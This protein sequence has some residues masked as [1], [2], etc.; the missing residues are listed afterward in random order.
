ME[1]RV[2]IALVL[3]FLALYFVQSFLGQPAPKRQAA[4]QTQPATQAT[5]RPAAVT[6]S[7]TAAP[8]AGKSVSA[9]PASAVALP[10][11]AE[12][13]A[14]AVEQD[15][16]VMTKVVRAVFSNRGAHLKSWELRNFLDDQ[17]QPVELVPRKMPAGATRPFMLKLDDANQ[18]TELNTALFR[19]NGEGRKEIDATRSPARIMFEF[20]DAAGLTARKTF[21]LS[22]DSYVLKFGAEVTN[23]S[24]PANVSIMWGRGLGDA[25]TSVANRYLQ[26]PQ[27]ILMLDGKVERLDP[28]S[29]SK[30]PV[31]EGN[32]RFAGVDDHYFVAAA[33]LGSTNSR[34]EFAS[35]V[36]PDPA[37]KEGRQ[38][39]SFVLNPK[40]QAADTKFFF[41]PK[42]FDLLREADP[43]FVRVI[44]FGVF[45]FLAVPLLHALNGVN[46]YLG[47]YGWSIIAL[48]VFINALIFPL[49]HKSVV[50][51]RKLQDLQ[52][53][54]KAIQARYGKLKTTDPAR[55]KMN[56]EMMSLYK[57]RGVNPASGCVP[58]LLTIP[59]LFAFY[60]LLSQAVELRGAPFGLWIK[61]LSV[62]D[63]LYVTPILMGITMFV[64]QKMT[65]STMDPAQQKMMMLMPAVFLFMFLWAPSGLVIYWFVSNLLAIAQQYFTNRLIGP[66]KLVPRPAAGRTKAVGSGK[67]PGA[68]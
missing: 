30:Q 47:N 18:T 64:Q 7:P 54:I 17:K 5:E 28:S 32:I 53:E 52:P 1:K 39:A 12:G 3:S 15:I 8:E 43:E 62:H 33:L 14:A 31:R 51:M 24:Q 11:P 44:N 50:S 29:I 63:P 37:V 48:T 67:S 23:G 57:E 59:V 66:P 4:P 25:E 2:L 58:T 45:A 56:Q 42:N 19:L 20:R 6:G 27:G 26:K 22:P 36:V 40:G 13:F 16:V 65:P 38:F 10:A 35:E 61:D 46:A 55:Q 41:G 34:I 60:S 68:A 49:R 21:D 9:A